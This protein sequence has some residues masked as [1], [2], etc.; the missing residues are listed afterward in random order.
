LALLISGAAQAQ[1]GY[2]G[3]IV[4]QQDRSGVAVPPFATAPGQEQVG[5]ELAA[6]MAYD[7]E[8][9]GEYRIL[10]E[11]QYP[12]QF[13]GFTADVSRIQFAPWRTLNIDFL[14]YGYVTSQPGRTAV[15]CILYDVYAGEPLFSKDFS[16]SNAR[17]VVHHIAE[18]VVRQASGTLGVATSQICFSGGVPGKKEIYLA[19]YDGANVQRITSHNSVS[20]LPKLSPN[21]SKVA[22]VSFKDR[23]PFLYVRELRTGATRR[24]SSAPGINVT[25]DWS[26]DGRKIA[27]TMSKDANP[28]IYIM[29]ADGSGKKRLTN[30]KAVDTQ[31]TFSPDSRYIAFVSDRGGSEQI[32]AMAS[33]GG[34]TKR[35]S[36][37]GGNSTDPAWSPDGKMIAYVVSGR[38]RGFQIWVME[39]NGGNPR[40]LTESGGTNEKPSWSP[41]SRH[42]VFSS[43]R[44]GR[45]ELWT[46]D[47]A[48]GLEERR[49]A[50]IQRT[51]AQGPS[52]GPRRSGMA[53]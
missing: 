12:P 4:G 10:P 1:Q 36:Y 17:Y 22:Y 5:R 33:T 32:L 25:P 53:R 39:V 20:I 48:T 46:V 23:F 43:T 3:T 16:G 38:G 27:L 47:V 29:N 51:S 31:P 15:R 30:H 7:L 37:Q 42:I 11:Q 45:A 28:E 50:G 19:D 35:L 14:V 34:P 18:E 26:G 41:D 24:V 9:S 44:S 21:G 40:Q 52:W 6:V 2:K 8:F 49:V 13:T